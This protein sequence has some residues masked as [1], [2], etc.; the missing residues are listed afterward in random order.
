MISELIILQIYSWEANSGMTSGRK[1]ILLLVSMSHG[2]T[3]LG[4]E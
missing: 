1:T 3:S 4:F 2:E